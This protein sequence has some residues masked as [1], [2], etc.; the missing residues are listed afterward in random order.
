MFLRLVS[1]ATADHHQKH[2]PSDS[3]SETGNNLYGCLKQLYLL[4][5]QKR[6]L[7][8][9]LSIGGWTYSQAGGYPYLVLGSP[10]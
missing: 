7:K 3:W 10:F 6:N 9:L 8:V 5:L 4:K 2:Y 1:F